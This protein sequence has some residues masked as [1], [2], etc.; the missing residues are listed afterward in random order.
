MTPAAQRTRL[1]YFAWAAVCLIWGTTYLGIRVSLESVPP[2]LMGGIRWVVAGGLLTAYLVARRRPLPPVSQWGGIALLGFLMLGLGNGGVVYA[3]QYV[4]SGLAAVIVA[5]A[6]FWMAAVEACLPDG[7]R[8]RRSTVA[9]LVIGFSGIVLLVWPDL[10][11]G[12]AGS[13]GFLAGIVAL[14][15]ASIGW[16]IGS[17]YSRRHGRKAAERSPHANGIDEVLGTT[18]FQMLAGGLIMTAAG[19]MLGEWSTIFFTTRTT[20]AM[21]YLATIGA[22]GGFVA[23]AYALRHLPVSFVSLYAYINPVIAVALGV[24]VLHEPFTWRMAVAAALV[25]AGV[26]VVRWEPRS[27]AGRRA[28]AAATSTAPPEAHPA[29]DRRSVA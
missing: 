8:L 6:P 29:R 9:G 23:Y 17:S 25:F 16:S 2:A 26:A 1:A 14:Q 24:L 27:R 13:R 19:T 4:P 5:T 3:E 11:R 7:E 10:T 20:V 22:I 28:V 18:A 15:I 12:S 21:L